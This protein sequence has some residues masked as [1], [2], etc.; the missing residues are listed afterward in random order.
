MSF[1]SKR[2]GSKEPDLSLSP[3]EWDEKARGWILAKLTRGPRTKHQLWQMLAQRS[4][5]E[6]IA[7]QLLDRFE[8]VGLIDDAHYAKAF[9]NDR[10]ATRGLAKSALK[11]ELNQAGVAAEHIDSALE[12]IDSEADLELATQLIRKR[13]SSVSSLERNARQRRLMGFL[14]RRG[15]GGSTIAA[16]IRTVEQE[17]AQ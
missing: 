12:D 1:K 15:F 5:P 10:R 4:V 9:T 16:A 7:A 11:R 14:G 13:W 2:F 3:E 17:Q 8:D 6:D